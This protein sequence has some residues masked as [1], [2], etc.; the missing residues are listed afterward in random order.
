[1]SGWRQT[2]K[3]VR[4]PGF[5]ADA[6]MDEE[7]AVWV[8]STLHRPQTLSVGAPES[9]GP[10]GVEVV[11]FGDVGAAAGRYPAQFRRRG[12]DVGGVAVRFQL[13]SRSSSISA[14]ARV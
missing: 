7:Q 10:V 4:A 2:F 11:A 9:V 1:M 5:A 8:V 6:V 12:L 14:R 13:Q 3:A